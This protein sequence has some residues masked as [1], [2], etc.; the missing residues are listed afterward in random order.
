MTKKGRKFTWD[1]NCDENF[2]TLN[3][4]LTT[5]PILTLPLGV[6]G[7]FIYTVAY[8]LGYRAVLMQQGKMIAYASRQLKVHEKNYTSQ[9]LEL[10]AVV[11]ALIMWRNYVYGARF[12][13]FTDHKNLNYIF[14]QQDLNLKQ[15]R[16]LEFIK[17]TT[18]VSPII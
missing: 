17:A 13:V 2:Q 14:R 3:N 12:E 11:F 18:L 4:C 6:D 8:I 16:L 1:E 7:F 15:R 9:D 10:E 5:T